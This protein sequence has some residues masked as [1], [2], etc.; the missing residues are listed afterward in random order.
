MKTFFSLLLMI[1]MTSLCA[2][3]VPLSSDVMYGKLDNGLTYYIQKNSMPKE[4]AMFY[5]VVNAGAINEN[6]DQNGLAHFCEH[7]AFNGTK[8]FPDKSI[9]NYLESIG[10]SFGGGLNAYTSSALTCYTL[11]NIPLKREGYI[12]SALLILREWAS[13]VTYSDEEINKERGVIHEEWRTG[14]GANLRMSKKTNPVLFEGSKYANHNV[15]GE[16]NIIDNSSPDFLRSYYKKW[17][18][19]DLQAII[20]VGDID[21]EAIRE[22]IVKLFSDI[23][24][25]KDKPESVKTLVKDNKEMQVAIASDKEATNLYMELTYKHPGVEV[26]DLG[27]LKSRLVS[28]LYNSMFSD[29][30][31]ELLQKGNPPMLSAY[32]GYGSLTKYQDA[33][34]VGVYAL[35]SDPIRSFKAALT[36]SERVRRFG[37]TAP[38]LKRAK[39]RLLASYE[40]S[41]NEKD[42]RLSASIVGE[43]LS[44][45]TSGYPAPGITYTYE[46]AKSFLP[47]VTLEQVNGLS[48]KWIT[49]DNQVLVVTGPEKE[50]IKIPTEAELKAA[51]SEVMSSTI[52]PYTEKAIPTSLISYELKGSPVLKKEYIKNIDGMKLTLANGAKVWLKYT[53]NKADEIS[54]HAVSYGGNSLI[55][56]ADLPSASLAA[57]ARNMCGL[58]E[59]SNQDLRKFL[60]GKNANTS[61]IITELEEGIYGTSSVKDFETMLQLFYLSFMPVRHDDEALK[62]YIQRSKASLANRNANPNAT[63]SDTLSMLLTNYSPRTTLP[64]AGFYDRMNFEKAYAIADDRFKNAGDFYFVFIGNIDTVKMIPLIEKYIGSIPDEGRRETWIDYKL[65]PKKEHFVK[66]IYVDM[67]DPKAMNYVF[68]YGEMPYTPEYIEYINAL[69]YILNMRYVTSIREKEGG[70]YSVGVSASTNARPEHSYKIS[71]NFTCAPE[72]ADYLRGLLIDELTNIKTKG[73]TEEEVN[74]TREN[75]L[76]D[77]AERMKTNSYIMDRV[78]CYIN[79]ALYT[80]LPENSTEIY[81]NLDGKKI[82]EM[83]NEIF[84]DNYFEFVMMPK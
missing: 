7:M 29:R 4:R 30:I 65:W 14:G 78:K 77:D 9:L 39:S 8:A 48:A 56:T 3:V 68:F 25:R 20:V 45:F 80:P 41:F 51:K 15:I 52:E 59:F 1:G 79:N 23:P 57:T 69:R 17:Y 13:N 18:R 55:P 70:T 46:L 22:K 5:L 27:Y 72:R 40:R 66:K 67:K 76:K 31:S 36:E 34:Y 58:G 6:E 11:N 19:P 47:T 74:M 42:K 2:Q 43:Y 61:T 24:K 54:L 84:R 62:S 75:F 32:S 16:V 21:Q 82:Q 37:F 10:V 53:N 73:V 33:Y 44:N 50:G 60:A 64:N 26:K 83:A 38:E 81:K 49:D 28:S 12:D 63:F 35:T 71:M